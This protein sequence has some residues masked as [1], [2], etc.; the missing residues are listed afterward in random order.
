MMQL[1]LS[2]LLSEEFAPDTVVGA[3]RWAVTPADPM[4]TPMRLRTTKPPS[5]NT[6]PQK[7]CANVCCRRLLPHGA[8]MP[9]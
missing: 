6:S 2:A 3:A 8:Q 4:A 9:T 1:S 5:Q 7:R